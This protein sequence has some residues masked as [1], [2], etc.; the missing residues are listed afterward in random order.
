VTA[1]AEEAR[2]AGQPDPSFGAVVRSGAPR[3]LREL[4]GPV[5]VFYV[6]WKLGGIVVGIVAS[7]AVA[8][9]LEAYERRHGRRGALALVSAAFVLVQ[10]TIG[11]VADSA[12]VYLAQPVLV[13]AIWGIA[14]IVSTL[15]GRPLMGVFADAW[16]PFPR[17]VKES[18]AYREIFGFESIVWGVY[19]LA[20]SGLRMVVLLSGSIGFF[21]VVQFVTGIPITIALV[22]WSI[23]YAGRSFERRLSAESARGTAATTTP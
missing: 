12:V 6:G 9:A 2:A 14:N 7:T 13:S 18:D 11:L 20:R 15:I 8:L 4:F 19:L 16:Y 23:W 3:F 17:E 5:A 1:L 10:A 21:V 22:A